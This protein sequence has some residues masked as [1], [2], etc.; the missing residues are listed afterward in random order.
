MVVCG[1]VCVDGDGTINMVNKVIYVC[2]LFENFSGDYIELHVS[3]YS[4]FCLFF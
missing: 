2:L 1:A 3:K 4:M